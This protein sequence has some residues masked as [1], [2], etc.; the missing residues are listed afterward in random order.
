MKN[1]D[2]RALAKLLLPSLTGFAVKAPMM[3]I[4]PIGHTLRGVYFESDRYESSAFFLW[5]FVQPMFVPAQNINF[6]IG[7]RI[8]LPKQGS[9]DYNAPDLLENL[10]AALKFQA[11][12][13]LT[14]IVTPLDFAN[15]V[16]RRPYA[17]NLN[18][19]EAMAYAY[20]RVGEGKRAVPILNEL[21]LELDRSV[22]WQVEMHARAIGFSSLLLNDPAG[23]QRQLDEWESETFSN[24]NLVKFR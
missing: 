23:A 15:E 16:Y 8:E 6:D 1:K 12:P 18:L 9:W 10:L 24:L 14:S 13:F 21:I 19:Q 7:N 3:F 17:R 22:P 20:A 2:I 4:A 5:T 11:L